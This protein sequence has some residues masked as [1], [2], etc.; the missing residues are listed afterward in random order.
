MIER[1]RVLD[2]VDAEGQTIRDVITFVHAHPE[3]GHEE[4]E[5]S[6]YLCEV[7]EGAGLVVERPLAGMETAFHARAT[8]AADGPSVG[9]VCLYDAVAAVRPDGRTEALHSCG[10]APIAGGVTGAALALASLAGELPG[11]VSV[12][13]CPAD[14]IHAPGTIVRGGGKAL[15][16]EAG[17]WDDM[18]AALY[19]HPEFIDTVS[20]ESR[21]L[22]RATAIVPGSRMLASADQPPYAA[23]AA[24]LAEARRHVPDNVMLERLELDGDVEEATGLVTKATFLLFGDEEQEV[25]AGLTSRSDSASGRDLGDRSPVRRGA[26]GRACDRGCRRRVPGARARLRSDPPTPPVRDGLREHL[27]TVSGGADRRRPAGRLEVPH[28]R[29]RGGVRL[30]GRRGG[31]DDRRAGARARGARDPRSCRDLTP[32]EELRPERAKKRRIPP[33]GFACTGGT[34]IGAASLSSRAARHAANCR[35]ELLGDAADDGAHRTARQRP[36]A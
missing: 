26:A 18:D 30:G 36:G 21:W 10:H 14:E 3:L 32:P 4:V 9:F 28:G 22:R 1:Q 23:A 24:A 7:F 33:I 17:V 25:E 31:G 6:R 27:A 12:I 2:A 29:G 34:S 11:S 15:T 19:A 5:C 8:G 13:G 16:A 20:V 35:A